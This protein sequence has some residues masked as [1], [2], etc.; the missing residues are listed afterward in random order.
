MAGG[1]SQKPPPTP[2]PVPQETSI[3]QARKAREE[4]RFQLQNSARRASLL[5]GETYNTGK[6]TLLGE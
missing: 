2:P 1:S 4:R 6:K 3:D 5:A